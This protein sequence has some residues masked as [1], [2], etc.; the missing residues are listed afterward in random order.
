MKRAP[1]LCAT[2][3]TLVSCG[4]ATLEKGNWDE[5]NH[6][7]LTRLIASDGKDSRDYDKSRKPYAVFDFD[8]TSI[9]GDIGVATMIYQ[10][11]NLELRLSPDEIW[12]SFTDLF[13]DIEAPVPGLGGI[14]VR[15]LASDITDDYRFL[16]DKYISSSEM[17]LEDIMTRPEYLDFRAKTYALCAGSDALGYEVG[18]LWILRLFNG[19]TK[20]EARNIARKAADDALSREKITKETWESPDRG[21]AG[22]VKVEFFRGIGI[23]PEMTDLYGTLRRNGID[24]YICSASMK[25]VVEAVAC[26]PKY[27]FGVPAGHVHGIRLKGDKIIN[28]EYDPSWPITFK[29]GKVECIKQFIAPEHGH[30]SPV[31]VAGDSN[32]DYQ[33]LTEFKD[34]S[35]GLIINRGGT[36]GIED[37]SK[38][39]EA[40]RDKGKEKSGTRYL[41]QGR[42]MT[43]KTFVKSYKS[44]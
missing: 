33:M 20:D 1:I 2:L 44:R 3:L 36:G 14:S 13:P 12:T 10:L 4:K 41:L 39:A 26:D 22:K 7:M 40:S 21:K 23:T 15:E 30:R 11:E 42:D 5:Y 27:G 25:E 37:L 35:I 17:S 6:G 29:E 8:N 24:V 34:L 38:A 43:D 28:A 16:F 32:G 19:M 18:C 9:I 31:L